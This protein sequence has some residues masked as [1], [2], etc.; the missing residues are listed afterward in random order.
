MK[1]P[2][3]VS[4]GQQQNPIRRMRIRPPNR[5]QLW[6][7]TEVKKNGWSDYLH[8]SLQVDEGPGEPLLELEFQRLVVYKRI[9]QIEP[10]KSN[11]EGENLGGWSRIVCIYIYTIYTYIYIYILRSICIGYNTVKGYMSR[12]E[13]GQCVLASPSCRETM[14]LN[15]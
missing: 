15:Y 12:W 2:L 4:V 7:T 11:F 6:R 1:G 13:R 14:E 9:Q 3:F 10:Q 8:M 5:C